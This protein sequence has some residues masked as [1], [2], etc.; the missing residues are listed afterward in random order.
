MNNEFKFV[1]VCVVYLYLHNYY[2]Y[3]YTVD[4]S[5]YSFNQCLYTYQTNN[6]W[7]VLRTFF[8]LWKIYS[9]LGSINLI[10][11][12]TLKCAP[13][14]FK[15]ETDKSSF[16]EGGSYL[17][18]VIFGTRNSFVGL[19][20]W[21]SRG[22]CIIFRAHVPYTAYTTSRNRYALMFSMKTN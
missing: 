3:T 4:W 12:K 9:H 19:S 8:L 10:T 5:K 15:S 14:F 21:L 16:S 11:A 6:K 2:I 13:T 17:F 7:K 22:R 1:L 20:I 18:F